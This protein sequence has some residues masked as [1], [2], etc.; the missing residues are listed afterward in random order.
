MTL[1]PLDTD[2]DSLKVDTRLEYLFQGKDAWR[3]LA[4]EQRRGCASF[5][6][7]YAIT[8]HKSQGSQW[9]SVALV[10]ESGAFRADG[11][12]WLY[13]GVTRAAEML[14]VYTGRAA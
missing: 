3:D 4:P 9:P 8:V 11:Q 13:T 5:S 7:A 1:Q 14:T 2:G 12:K 10:D 6:F